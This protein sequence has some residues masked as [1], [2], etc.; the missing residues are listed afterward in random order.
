MQLKEDGDAHQFE[1][2]ALG[3]VGARPEQEK[4]GADKGIDGKLFFIGDDGKSLE[5]IILSVKSGH[6]KRG[7]MH[8]L[9]GVVL[10]EKAVI[11]VLITMEP[12]TK[13][14]HEEVLSGGFYE[15]ATWGK[16]YP[17][18]QILTIEEIMGGKG[19]DMP[20]INQ[21]NATFIKAK[22]EQTQNSK[23]E[24]GVLPM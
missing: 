12:P 22:K 9:N 21:V 1:Y 24:Q 18:M 14:M 3:L 6:V 2:W 15:S 13:N 17:R 20:P 4:K 5:T 11:G 23:N 8:E 16:K 19:I 10:R 7:F